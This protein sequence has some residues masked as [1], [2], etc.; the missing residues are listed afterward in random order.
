MAV[1]IWFLLHDL[2]TGSNPLQTPA[3]LGNAI[4]PGARSPTVAAVSSPIVIS[5]TVLHFAVF[6]AFGVLVAG[7]AASLDEPLL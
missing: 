6:V 5:Y 1:V 4:L 2:G 7:L 3:I